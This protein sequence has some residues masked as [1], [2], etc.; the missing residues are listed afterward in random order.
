MDYLPDQAPGSPLGAA[1]GGGSSS[2]NNSGNT[3]NDAWLSMIIR[4][5][6]AEINMLLP[7]TQPSDCLLTQMGEYLCRATSVIAQLAQRITHGNHIDTYAQLNVNQMER[8]TGLSELGR[9]DIMTAKH[10]TLKY[11]ALSSSPPSL[12]EILTRILPAN[13]SLPPLCFSALIGQ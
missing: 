6:M 8:Q 5:E 4:K 11:S 7:E 3:S 10:T 12:A 13:L 1:L 2:N 9:I